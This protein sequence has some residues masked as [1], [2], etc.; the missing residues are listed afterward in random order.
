MDEIFPGIRIDEEDD[1]FLDDDEDEEEAA[2]DDE[3]LVVH[4]RG[5]MQHVAGGCDK[6]DRDTMELDFNELTFN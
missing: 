2:A 6:S 4:T 5:G 1:V 3:E